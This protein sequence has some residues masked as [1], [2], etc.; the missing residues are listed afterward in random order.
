MKKIIILFILLFSVNYSIYS[1]S[2]GSG[3]AAGAQQL[4]IPVGARSMGMN[5]AF[6]SGID[7]IEA[8]Y[9]NPAGI[10]HS[11]G[12]IDA[13]F[14]YMSF[15]AD[16]GLSYAA[17]S[18][19]LGDIGTVALSLKSLDVGDIPVTTTQEAYG[20]GEYFSPTL[21][22]G[23]VSYANYLSENLSIGTNV[24]IIYERILETS[25][26]GVSFDFGMQYRNIA[27][28]NGLRVGAVLRNIG[29]QM[30]YDGP[31]LLRVASEES[32]SR[33][34]QFY[35]V[36]AAGFDLPTLFEIGVSYEQ[37]IAER[38]SFLFAASYLSSSF[39]EDELKFAGEFNYENLFFIRGGYAL[40]PSDDV[41]DSRVFGP[42]FGA[43]VHLHTVFNVTV[44]YA[45]RV[46][47]FFNSNHIFS[48]KI[49]F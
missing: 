34:N 11:S 9:Y 32:D 14:S 15:I 42:T 39:F 29:P 33:G 2:S 40:N 37:M 41:Y 45:Y 30:K 36:D 3:G 21:I 24:N 48:V 47:R 22:I 43:G 46:A 38:Y 18:S 6:I 10:I 28:V 23:G 26:A 49:S 12:S 5:G 19:N 17:V 13:M 16:I 31:D 27:D 44:D 1:Q 20:T 4:L 35:K 8:I 25:A 7:G